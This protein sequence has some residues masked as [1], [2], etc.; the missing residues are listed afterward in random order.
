MKIVSTISEAREAVKSARSAGKTI[1]LVPTMGS[2]HEGHLSLVRASKS[3]CGFTA[4]SIFVNPTQFNSSEDYN[5]YPRDAGRDLELLDKEGVDMVFAPPFEEMYREKTS[6]YIDIGKLSEIFEGKLR[7]GH[8]RGVCTVVCKLFNIIT[9]DRAY[10]GWKDAQQLIIIKKM[11]KALN[12]PVEV[13]GC[14]TVRESDG[15]AASSRNIFIAAGERERALCLY[16]SLKKIEELLLKQ[17]IRDTAILLE[18]GRKIITKYP[19]VELQ[20]LEIT[21]AENLECI[22]EVK[23]RAL[24]L[25]AI[26]LSRVRLIDNLTLSF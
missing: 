25:G 11:V 16:K 12:M 4:A 15:L 19:D 22:E 2:L 24:V 20:Y 8:F 7:P 5:T 10:F 18:E 17:N 14:P 13:I 21:D 1:G 6:A 3:A 26:K 9:P 23:G